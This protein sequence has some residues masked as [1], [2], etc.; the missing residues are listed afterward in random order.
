[1]APP[2]PPTRVLQV[3]GL[4]VIEIPTNKPIVRKDQNDL[5]FQT[6][7]G[8]SLP[9]SRSNAQ[10]KGQ[11]VLIGTVSIENN[12]LLSNYLKRESPAQCSTLKIRARGR[13]SRQ[14]GKRTSRWHQHGGTRRRHQA[15][16]DSPRRS[17]QEVKT[18]RTL[19]LGTE[20]HEARPST[21][22]GRSGPA[23]RPGRDAVLFRSRTA[24]CGYSL[25]IPSESDGALWNTGR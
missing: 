14:G 1:M 22:R 21:M 15:R 2:R 11:P 17:R 19:C 6:E 24:L 25:R 4:E 13:D 5:I 20:R 12:E 3:Y 16:R 9:R 23:G 7:K 8:R 18:R 10:P